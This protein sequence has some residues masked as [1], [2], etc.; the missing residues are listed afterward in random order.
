MHVTI[1]DVGLSMTARNRFPKRFLGAI[2][3]EAKRNANRVALDGPGSGPA[4][5][6]RRRSLAESPDS[7]GAARA[8]GYPGRK[9]FK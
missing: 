7:D 3:L 5:V 6:G 9:L 8:M 1:P 2:C 4:T